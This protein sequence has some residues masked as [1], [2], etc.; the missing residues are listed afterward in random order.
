MSIKSYFFGFIVGLPV[1]CA[2]I[3][4]LNATKNDISISSATDSTIARVGEGAAHLGWK[5]NLIVLAI[6][7]I[8]AGVILAITWRFRDSIKIHNRIPKRLLHFKM[9]EQRFSFNTFRQ[10][11]SLAISPRIGVN[12]SKSRTSEASQ[13]DVE[14]VVPPRGCR[15]MGYMMKYS[16][17][18]KRDSW[19]VSRDSI[20]GGPRSSLIYDPTTQKFQTSQVPNLATIHGF[21]NEEDEEYESENYEEERRDEERLRISDVYNN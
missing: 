21:A 6:L 8:L 14:E 19:D 17:G 9:T 7:F 15:N 2:N 16:N 12:K 20:T 18:M 1:G 11:F 3:K 13:I 4:S 10:R 5:V